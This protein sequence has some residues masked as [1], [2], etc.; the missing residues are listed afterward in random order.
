LE[1]IDSLMR[2]LQIV[3]KTFIDSYYKGDIILSNNITKNDIQF[4]IIEN[5]TIPKMIMKIN[6]DI[7]F[8]K[9]YTYITN[10]KNDMV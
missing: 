10:F 7:D 1:Q 2:N 3:N 5:K 6:T 8:I 4:S 9:Y